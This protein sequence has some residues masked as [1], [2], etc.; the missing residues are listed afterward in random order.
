MAF[1]NDKRGRLDF[2]SAPKRKPQLLIY[3]EEKAIDE[4]QEGLWIL[5]GRFSDVAWGELW[6]KVW[7][8]LGRKFPGNKPRQHPRLEKELG[9]QHVC[10]CAALLFLSSCLSFL[11]DLLVTSIGSLL[12][13]KASILASSLIPVKIDCF[14]VFYFFKKIV[15]SLLSVARSYWEFAWEGF[16]S[17]LIIAREKVDRNGCANRKKKIW[18]GNL[19]SKGKVKYFRLTVLSSPK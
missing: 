19:E 18:E 10:G 4:R 17:T 1:T 13:P 9:F 12:L 7:R 8:N 5:S 14:S 3:A 6:F 2:F 15:Y 11:S 16:S